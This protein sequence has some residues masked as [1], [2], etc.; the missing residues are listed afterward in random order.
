MVKFSN[1]Q[2]GGPHQM[3]VQGKNTITID[4][5]LIGEVWL[6]SGQSNMG[7]RVSGAQNFEEE[8]NRRTCRRFTCL[9]LP[10][11]RPP[12]RKTTAKGQWVVC[13]PQTVGDFSATLYFFGR[14]VYKALDVPTGLINSSVGGTPIESWIDA[15]AQHALPELKGFFEAVQEEKAFNA[16]DAKAK[17][18][19]AL[20]RW[21]EAAQKAKK[22]GAAAPRR[23]RIRWP[24]TSRKGVSAAC[25]TARS[26]H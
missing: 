14:E 24:C 8:Q 15:D 7:L 19:K 11:A 22:E 18:E 21:K 9:P 26:R 25:S 23:P 6:G 3:T 1:L 5:V 2:A 10:P 17:Y 12:P 13:A 16:A 4:D 20:A